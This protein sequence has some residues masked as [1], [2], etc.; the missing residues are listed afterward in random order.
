MLSLLVL[1]RLLRRDVE[2]GV[3]TVT[4]PSLSFPGIVT[5]GNLIRYSDSNLTLPTLLRVT[6]VNTNSL[7]V[8][9]VETVTS[10][11]LMVEFQI[12][13]SVSQI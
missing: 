2:S 9:G 4:N 13:I 6:S 11:L 7:N 3:S 1:P 5:T 8:V 10:P 12:V